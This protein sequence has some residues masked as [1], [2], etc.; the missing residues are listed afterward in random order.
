VSQSS[1]RRSLPVSNE[2]VLPTLNVDGT[3]R[4]VRPKVFEGKYLLR[5]KVVAGL[6]VALFVALPF[7]S[8]RGKP[9][10]L[11]DVVQREFTLFGATFRATEGGLLMLLMLAIFV[12]IFWLT[13]VYGRVWCGYGCP[14]TIY[15]EFV[16]R[17]IERWLEGSRGQQQKLDREGPDA[18]RLLKYA[19]YVVLSWLLGNLFLSYFVGVRALS[20][21]LSRSPFE[22]PTPFLVMFVAAALVFFD[23][24]YFREQMCSIACPY[25][26]LQSVLLDKGSAIL[27]YDSARGEPR[28]ARHKDTARGDCIDCR[29]CV[30]ACPA[31]IDI[32]DGL[33]LECIACAQCADA[34]DGV[35]AKLKRPL[36]LVRYSTQSELTA[37]RVKSVRPR[38]LLYPAM[39]IVLLGALFWLGRGAT[40]PK[41]TVLRGAG[42][43]FVVEADGRVRNQLRVKIHNRFDHRESFSI[44]L[45]GAPGSELIAPENPVHAEPNEMT[46]AG[47]FVESPAALFSNGKAAVRVVVTTETGFEVTLP[48]DLLG[49]L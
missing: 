8:V 22:Q 1:G 7:I 43:P 38:T 41:V 16:F 32:R 42:I 47:V 24:A 20:A 45:A 19:I 44:S 35:M 28:G 13:A 17:P 3:R 40:D 34:C 11:L 25:A 37:E 31:G 4:W 6:L 29:A 5:R 12:A 36:G 27:A 26:R 23:F 39:L 10:V 21:W 46:T 9:A 14:Q 33:Q 48:Y 18:R 15:L 49:P 2:R 30:V